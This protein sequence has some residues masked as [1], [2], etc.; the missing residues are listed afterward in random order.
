[1]LNGDAFNF[2]VILSKNGISNMMAA[3]GWINKVLE[4][5]LPQ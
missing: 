1:M 4:K 2:K 3:M 5:E